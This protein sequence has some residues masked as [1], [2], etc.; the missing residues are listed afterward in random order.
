MFRSRSRLAAVVP[1]VA[2]VASLALARRA[3]GDALPADY[4]PPPCT[5]PICV[6]GSLPGGGSH[7]GCATVCVPVYAEC[8]PDGSCAADARCVP[9]RFCI[10]MRGTGRV[11]QNVVLSECATDGSCVE[12]TCAE[13]ARCVTIP[14]G[15]GGPSLPGPRAGGG[16]G[17]AAG[18]VAA[19]APAPPV[20]SSGGGLCSA[21]VGA[22]ATRGTPRVSI[23]P[24]LSVAVLA[25]AL[26]LA[27][28]RPSRRRARRGS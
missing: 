13:V 9:T 18:G 22:S 20:P 3:R 12:G 25:S 26:A 8:A 14:A 5:P 24:V 4:E 27:G 2:L 1:L 21:T 6:E 28:A 16:A 15:T 11:V 10:D 23:A 17:S 7:G 19:P